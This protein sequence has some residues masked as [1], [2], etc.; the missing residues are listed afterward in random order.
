MSERA[1]SSSRP[2][3]GEGHIRA[4]STQRSAL[5]CGWVCVRRER[6]G[7]AIDGSRN[8]G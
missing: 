8:A 1:R 7:Q 6:G 2:V 4:D 3:L 5:T